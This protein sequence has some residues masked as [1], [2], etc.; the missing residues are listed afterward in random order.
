V[1]RP[2]HSQQIVLKRAREKIGTRRLLDQL[3]NRSCLNYI[4]RIRV[5]DSDEGYVAED[6]ANPTIGYT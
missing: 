6:M 3:R 5:I 1:D 2:S 4:P